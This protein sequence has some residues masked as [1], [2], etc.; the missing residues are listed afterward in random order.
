MTAYTAR[1]LS[2]DRLQ[3]VITQASHG[4]VVGDLV[5]N[6]ALSG[7]PN[8]V[9]SQADTLL[10][11][12]GTMM[13]SSI[14]DINTFVAT[15]VGYV[16]NIVSQ[17]ILAGYTYYVSPTLVN[18]LTATEP[19][20]VGQI[21]LPCFVADSTT[22]GFFFGGFGKLIESGNVFSWS[23]VAINTQMA[24]N[25]GYWTNSGGTLLMTLPP[26][27]SVGDTLQIGAV[28]GAFQIVQAAGQY[29]TIGANTTTV[30]V[31][32]NVLSLSD[33]AS[34]SLVCK[35]G[36]ASTGWQA[37]VAPQGSYTIT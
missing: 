14:I 8:Y 35:V 21:S 15:Q 22:S 5:V 28:T 17:T 30:G 13:V 2:T 16:I 29:V 4:F 19:T 11:C 31:G 32:G 27:A 6:A 23:T 3:D 33:G 34:L 37:D 18:T 24:I 20:T 36:G 9:K 12:Q 10:H 7:P 26:T 1:A 25:N